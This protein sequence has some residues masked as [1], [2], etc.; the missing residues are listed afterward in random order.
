MPA[1]VGYL[2]HWATAAQD[3]FRKRHSALSHATENFKNFELFR[4]IGST[5]QK[6]SSPSMKM[7]TN[8]PH[9]HIRYGIEA[10]FASHMPSD[11]TVGTLSI[12]LFMTSM[13]PDLVLFYPNYHAPA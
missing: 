8:A 13:I 6:L 2:N 10:C 3:P 7:L 9:L 1:M 12:P 11:S 4:T 5:N